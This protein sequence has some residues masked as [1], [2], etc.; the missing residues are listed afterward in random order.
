MPSRDYTKE[1]GISQN[2]K[3]LPRPI[4]YAVLAAV[5]VVVSFG[6]VGVIKETKEHNAAEHAAKTPAPAPSAAAVP[7]TPAK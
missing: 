5:A 7:A 2:K 6:V 3:T 1:I 4:A